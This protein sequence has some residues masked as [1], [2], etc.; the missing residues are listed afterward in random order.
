M[1]FRAAVLVALALVLGCGPVTLEGSLTQ[2][3]DLSYDVARVTLAPEDLAVTFVRRQTGTLQADGGAAATENLTFVLRM[4]IEQW[5]VDGGVQ[6]GSGALGFLVRRAPD[7]PATTW[8]DEGIPSGVA[9]DLTQENGAGAQRGSYSRNVDAHKVDFPK[10][11][12]AE[13][14]FNRA[15]TSGRAVA[16]DFHVTFENGTEGASGRTVYGS[17]AVKEVQ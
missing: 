9:I 15:P 6:P 1:D 5:R 14:R 3:Y 17:F 4:A 10:A 12:R 16:G 11:S 8:E 7:G 13:L 2:L